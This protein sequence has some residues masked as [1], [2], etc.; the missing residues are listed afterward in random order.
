MQA[1]LP[2]PIAKAKSLFYHANSAYQILVSGS[3]RQSDVQ[4]SVATAASSQLKKGQKRLDTTVPKDNLVSRISGAANGRP[5]VVLFAATALFRTSYYG[6]RVVLLLFVIAALSE[7]GLGW[8]NAAGLRL[9]GQFVALFLATP[10][11]GGLIADRWLGHARSAKIGLLVS[12]CGMAGLTGAASA[13]ESGEIGAANAVLR[14]ALGAVILGNGLFQASAMAMFGALSAQQGKDRNIGFVME[15]AAVCTGAIA[16]V[17]LVGSLAEM[18]SWW[19]GFVAAASAGLLAGLVLLFLYPASAST[20]RVKRAD[21]EAIS[22]RPEAQ[23][24]WGPYLTLVSL[25][26]FAL[27]FTVAFEQFGAL[28]VLLAQDRVDRTVSGFVVPVSWFSQLG[29][30]YGILLAPL[31]ITALGYLQ[32]RH[33]WFDIPYR[34]AWGLFVSALACVPIWLLIRLTEGGASASIFWLFGAYLLITVGEI[35][36]WPAGYAAVSL[37]AP[38]RYTGT[39]LGLWLL[40]VASIGTWLSAEV[41]AILLETGLL[42]GWTTLTIVMLLS[43]PAMLLVRK[44]LLLTVGGHIAETTR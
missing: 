11:V 40:L 27:L 18:V 36:L 12:A 37:L 17:L 35:A 41:A 42:S 9:Y 13:A 43:A 15:Y 20:S 25:G 6:S 10:L 34:F 23:M 21:H 4:I 29:S 3:M 38:T 28:V 1:F 22:P 33:R 8:T 14:L 16:G 26:V 5:L 2:D 19:A 30:A 44:L 31:W 24:S 7:G 39:A 32:R